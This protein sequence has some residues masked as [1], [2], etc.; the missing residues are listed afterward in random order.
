MCESDHTIQ[1]FRL[2]KTLKK[3][4]KRLTTNVEE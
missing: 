4:V 1:D 2:V 3:N